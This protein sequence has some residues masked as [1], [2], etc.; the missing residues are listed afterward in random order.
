MLCQPIR[1]QYY[2]SRSER[3]GEVSQGSE[4]INEMVGEVEELKLVGG[5]EH[6]NKIVVRNSSNSFLNK[7]YPCSFLKTN[8]RISLVFF[9]YLLKVEHMMRCI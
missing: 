7:C 9:V 3:I 5:A 2:L 8:Q 6:G 1:S 4:T